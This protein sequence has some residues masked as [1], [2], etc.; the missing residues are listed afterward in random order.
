MSLSPGMLTRALL[1]ALAFVNPAAAAAAPAAPQAHPD[2]LLWSRAG[3]A[4]AAAHAL[5][6]TLQAASR[7]GLSGAD[8]GAPALAAELAALEA[9]PDAAAAGWSHFDR[10]LSRAALA[11]IHDLHFGRIDPRSAGFDLPARTEAFDAT[12][13][14]GQLASRDDPQAVL[15]Q[16]EPAYL[17]YR[18]L[19]QALTRYRDLAAGPRPPDLPALHRSVKPGEYY[20]AA[21][22]LRQRL[23]L[24]GDLPPQAAAR[25]EPLL[26]EDLVAALKRF[27]YLHGLA[28]DGALGRNTLAALEVPFAR[29]VRQIELTL[30][31]WRWVPALRPPTLIVNIPQFRLFLIRAA[32]DDEADML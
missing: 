12:A 5:V 31:R 24:E 30:E 9:H 27:Q 6:A 21:A 26:D 32:I 18:L 23:A 25:T 20:A 4:T 8:Y 15:A 14:L 7:Y 19:L 22:Q 10:A 28:E 13:V 1:A 3:Q 29:R 11:V 17:H 2:A 16:I